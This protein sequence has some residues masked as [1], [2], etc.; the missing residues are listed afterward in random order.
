MLRMSNFKRKAH[1]ARVYRAWSR[2]KF[3]GVTTRGSHKAL[4]LDTWSLGHWPQLIC[5]VGLAD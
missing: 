4:V 2:E 5:K 1:V 3:L